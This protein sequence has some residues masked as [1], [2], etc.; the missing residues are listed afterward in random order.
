MHLQSPLKAFG[1]SAFSS[2]RLMLWLRRRCV[3]VIFVYRY[4]FAA[5]QN[6]QCF[7]FCS[8]IF[9]YCMCSSYNIGTIKLRSSLVTLLT[10]WSVLSIM[11]YEFLLLLKVITDVLVP[12]KASLWYRYRHHLF[13][14]SLQLSTMTSFTAFFCVC[15]VCCYLILLLTGHL[16]QFEREGKLLSSLV[17]KWT[18]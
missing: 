11:I 2:G 3:L 12:F 18:K 9:K 10:L 1:H 5:E 4:G 14:T 17:F 7:L 6:E 8:N 13:W 15:V 16:S